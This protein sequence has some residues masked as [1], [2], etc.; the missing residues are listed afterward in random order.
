MC[1][2]TFVLTH[3]HGCRYADYVAAFAA[4]M[5]KYGLRAEMCVSSWGIL[6][7]HELPNGE[8]CEGAPLFVNSV[9][10]VNIVSCPR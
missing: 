1:A 2:L 4:A 10:F 3:A 5:H 7:G 9:A 8:G 6:D